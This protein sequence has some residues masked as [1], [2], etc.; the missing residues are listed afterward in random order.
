M[1]ARRIALS[2]LVLIAAGFAFA[3]AANT[4]PKAAPGLRSTMPAGYDVV[5]L[6]PSKTT[7]SLIGLIECPELEGAQHV[8]AKD[9]QRGGPDR[10]DH[11]ADAFRVG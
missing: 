5:V 7:L 9:G 3:T 6:K 11:S 1:N 4:S 2:G 10:H 8:A